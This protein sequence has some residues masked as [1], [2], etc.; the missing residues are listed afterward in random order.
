MA[1]D[2]YRLNPADDRFNYRSSYA[3]GVDLG[4]SKDPTSVAVI[5]RI[6]ALDKAW[7]VWGERKALRARIRPR[8]NL[9]MLDQLP[10]GMPYPQ[11]V[12]H[13]AGILG[14]Q[15]L[16][17]LQPW[18]FIDYTGVGAPVFDIFQ[19]QRVPNIMGVTITAGGSISR[20]DRGGLSVPKVTL[21]SRLQALLHNGDLRHPANMP[22]AK[23]FRRELLDFRATYSNAGNIRFGA[24]EGM[25]D[26]LILAVALAVLGVE[27][28]PV[29]TPLHIGYAT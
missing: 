6:E 11:Q 10:L 2:E 29:T 18:T 19:Q 15:P 28:T 7:P 8:F 27:R 26:D 16:A 12:G 22:L 25:H 21:V 24:R 1:D 4:Q 23:P 3:V 14:R 5:E 9:L 17:E 20:N 13:I